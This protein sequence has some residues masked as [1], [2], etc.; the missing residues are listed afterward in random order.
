MP[1]HHLMI[2]I[3]IGLRAAMLAAMLAV[4]MA[5]HSSA[6]LAMPGAESRSIVTRHGFAELVQRLEQA[7]QAQKMVVVAKASASA[8]AA[9]RGVTI[10]GNAVIMVF[11]NDFAVRMLAASV[12]AG[13]ETPIRFYVTENVD[14]TATLTWRPPSSVFAPYGG[15]ELAAMAR[16]LDTIFDAIA[17]D[18]AGG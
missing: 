18:A 8:G 5:T 1:Q 3:M 2:T 4:A 10:P 15:G 13:Y 7:V 12:A 11:R 14:R 9:G 6:Q 16:E 17:R